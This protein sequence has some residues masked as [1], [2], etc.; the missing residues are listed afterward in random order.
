MKDELQWMA[1]VEAGPQAI[2]RFERML[3]D[4]AQGVAPLVVVLGVVDLVHRAFQVCVLGICPVHSG[5]G[6]RL[7]CTT[8]AGA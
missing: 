5:S 1:V 6:I 7:F 4:G 3:A 8:Y 2:E